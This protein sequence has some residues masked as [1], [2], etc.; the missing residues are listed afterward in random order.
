MN[1]VVSE[2]DK[3]GAMK[4]YKELRR[5]YN[6]Y[7]RLIILIVSLP[8]IYSLSDIKLSNFTLL[9]AFVYIVVMYFALKCINQWYLKLLNKLLFFELDI[10][11]W[12][13]YI[14]IN[15]MAKLKR[16]RKVS[17]I[18]EI[19]YRYMQGEFVH[20]VNEIDQLRHT[21]W[22]NDF[23]RKA[24]NVYQINSE[25]LSNKINSMEE[26]EESIEKLFL[27]ESEINLISKK[28]VAIFDIVIKKKANDY[29]KTIESEFKF[30]RLESMYFDALN[31]QL[32][33]NTL[34][35]KKLLKTISSEN[36]DIFIV[37]ESKKLLEEL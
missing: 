32:K 12:K 30:D 11:S 27:N 19:I 24:L 21:G 3:G 35:T 2:R 26:L 7:S 23:E 22:L 31:E 13:Q 36:T 9:I 5:R 28:A 25:I 14:Q 10:E 1:Y 18:Y 37:R 29:F 20:L 17:K 4:D 16:G 8:F 33:G 15:S 34:E 6:L